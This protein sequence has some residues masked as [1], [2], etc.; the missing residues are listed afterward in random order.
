MPRTGQRPLELILARNL[1][2]SLSTP[3]L[4][5]NREGDVVFYNDAAGT[6]LGRHFEE[7]GPMSAE[8]WTRIYGPFAEDGQPM[9]IERQPLTAVLRRNRPGHAR[10]VIRTATGSDCPVAVSG[11]PVIGSDGTKGA[12][13]FFWKEPDA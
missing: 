5:V 7:T 6:I 2:A 10:H 8:D 9:P 1:M 4:L 12:M 11:V 3:A 13:V